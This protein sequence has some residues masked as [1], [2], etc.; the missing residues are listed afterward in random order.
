MTTT[1]PTSTARF[2]DTDSGLV[3]ESFRLVVD[4]E[5]DGEKNDDYVVDGPDA[6]GVTAPDEGV[7][8]AGDL[9]G[10]SDD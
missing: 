10:Y 4:N 7:T 9:T 6:T 5:S 1:R 8:H 2:E 3:A